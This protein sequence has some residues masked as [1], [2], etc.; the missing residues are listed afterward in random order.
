MKNKIPDPEESAKAIHKAIGKARGQ[1]DETIIE[2]FLDDAQRR[3]GDEF[4]EN[5]STI[6]ERT[7]G[8]KRKQRKG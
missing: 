2:L 3:Y 6:L 7:T 4:A 8:W 1:I 5:L